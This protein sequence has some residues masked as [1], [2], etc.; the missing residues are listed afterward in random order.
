MLQGAEKQTTSDIAITNKVHTTIALQRDTKKRIDKIRVPRQC[1]DS[2][3]SELVEYWER[4]RIG[5]SLC[6]PGKPINQTT[7]R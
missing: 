3:I 1:Y 4:Y 2:V 5:S 7:E 6:G